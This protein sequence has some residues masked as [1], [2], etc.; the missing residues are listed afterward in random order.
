MYLLLLL[1]HGL[2]KGRDF[3]IFIASCTEPSPAQSRGTTVEGNLSKVR[4]KA[5]VSLY[6]GGGYERV[7]LIGGQATEKPDTLL[8]FGSPCFT[9]PFT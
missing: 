8:A 2:L 6:P 3:V 5:S 4:S 9:L 7:C 1:N